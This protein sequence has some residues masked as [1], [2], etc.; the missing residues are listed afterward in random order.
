MTMAV[1]ALYRVSFEQQVYGQLCVNVMHFKQTSGTMTTAQEV[2]E[3]IAPQLTQQWNTLQNNVDVTHRIVRVQAITR[4]LPDIGEQATVR[5][6]S[7]GPTTRSLSPTLAVVMT[8]RSGF[9]GRDN[10]GR[11]YLGGVGAVDSGGYVSDTNGITVL[12]T[13][14]A[15]FRNRFLEN[16]TSNYD[17]HIFSRKRFSLLSNPF[18]DWSRPVKTVSVSRLI[19]NQRRRRPTVGA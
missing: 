2:A 4:G 10:R 5:A 15:N 11:V 16:G 12:D 19:G 3:D 14:E 1:G 9:A 17:L 7:G 18:D 8:L 13:F 6:G